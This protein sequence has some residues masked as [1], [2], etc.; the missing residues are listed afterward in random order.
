MP[1]HAWTPDAD[2]PASQS[3]P[4]RPSPLA[5]QSSRE[6]ALDV[7]LVQA[8]DGVAQVDGDA[9]GQAGGEPEEAPLSC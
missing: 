5:A 6:E 9:G 7:V 4:G 1:I 8:G 3:T 2:N